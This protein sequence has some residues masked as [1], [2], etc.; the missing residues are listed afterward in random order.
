MKVTSGSGRGDKD[1]T[2]RK[3]TRGKAGWAWEELMEQT[4]GHRGYG[5]LRP[6][7]VKLRQK[8]RLE[9]SRIDFL[10]LI[11]KVNYHNEPF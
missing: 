3:A 11:Y 1:G 10:F 7:W 9:K 8:L 4:V 5:K 6:R 2:L